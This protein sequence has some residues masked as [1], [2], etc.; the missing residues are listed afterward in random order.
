MFYLLDRYIA[1][2]IF[3]NV[4]ITLL[5]LLSLSGIIK[6]IDQLRKIG[7]GNYHIT[8][9]LLYSIISFPQDITFF[10]S[11]SVL[12]GTLIGLGILSNNNEI[13]SMQASGFSYFQIILSVI[14]TT[15]P[16]ILTTVIISEF[17][18]PKSE[19]I[20]RSYR[21]QK[22]FGS[23]LITLKHG[24]WVKDGDNF[25]Y[26]KYLKNIN[27]LSDINIYTFNNEYNLIQ[28]IHAK[29]AKWQVTNKNWILFKVS[30]LTLDNRKI[31]NVYVPI[32][33]WK[34][35]ITPDKLF[36]LT[37]DPKSFSIHMLYNYIEYLKS[38]KQEYKSYQLNMWYK[39]FQPLSVVVMLIMAVSF[40]L[41]PLNNVSIGIRILIGIIFSFVFY[42]LNQI[43]SSLSLVYRF[44]PIFS[45][46]IP[47]VLFFIVSVICLIK[48]RFH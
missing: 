25:I 42:T 39:I 8:D 11:V 32:M 40:I 44:P 21:A 9:A 37:L 18:T 46:I 6:F 47:I 38:S 2:S 45:A 36:V 41:G 16:L 23:K 3:L 14:K 33:L 19:Q 15:A 10:F 5:T 24:L 28:L 31:I 29:L 26:I 30:Q 48:Y 27:T 17:I 1:K 20:A 22:I 34:T 7:Q 35:N 4:F 43:L 12:I 13:I